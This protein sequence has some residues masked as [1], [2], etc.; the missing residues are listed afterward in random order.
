MKTEN[1]L[2]SEFMGWERY[3]GKAFKCPNMYPVDNS[4]RAGWTTFTEDQFQ[5]HTSWDWLMPVVERINSTVSPIYPDERID[6]IIYRNT[7]HINDHR[8]ILIET[9]GKNMM[10]CTYKAVVEF[11][12]WYNQ[13]KG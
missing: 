8:E 1:E 3:S 5:F 10:D 13:Q 6:V 12:K 7:C 9:T 2:I 11:I 4:L